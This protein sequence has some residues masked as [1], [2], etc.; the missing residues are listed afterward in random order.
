SD[1]DQKT[2]SAT[3]TRAQTAADQRKTARAEFE[4]GEAAMAKNQPEEALVHY[5]AAANNRYVDSGTREKSL[6]KSAL[7]EATLRNTT[8]SLKDL[9]AQAK[10][11]YNAGNL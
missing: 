10:A 4:A 5:R 2:L 11:D 3:L 9:Y 8:G 1:K 6:E 7:S